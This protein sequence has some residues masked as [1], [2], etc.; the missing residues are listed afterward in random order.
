[1]DERDDRALV[2]RVVRH[3]DRE[4]AATLVNRH[5]REVLVYAGR[6]L[7]AQAADDLAQD[8]FVSALAHLDSFD[9]SRASF[10]TWLYRIATNKV[11]D[12][13]RR[14]AR[15]GVSMS[16]DFADADGFGLEISLDDTSGLA[17]NRIMI[18]R[19]LDLLG[20]LSARDQQVVRLRLLGE[21]PFREVAMQVGV[22]E[23]AAKSAYHRAMAWLR[24]RLEGNNR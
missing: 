18:D 9:P 20:S 5:Y 23:T 15:R 21:L 3:G 11:I 13:A 6:Q 16:L 2:R 12:R 8:V 1:M 7:G 4:A 10:R 17:L 14:D 24:V 19:F 22:T